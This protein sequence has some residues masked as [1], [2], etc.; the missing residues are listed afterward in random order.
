MFQVF[1]MFIRYVANISYRCCKSRSGC[2]I[3]CN[4]C[5][6]MLQASVLNISSVF[7]D[8][9]ARC[10]FG[11]CICFT[12][13]LQVF[14]LN[15]EYVCNGF[16]VFRLFLMYISSVSYGCC[17]SRSVCCICCN[18]CTRILQAYVPNVL[19]VSS[20][21]MLQVCLFGYC[22]CFTHMLQV[23]YLDVVYVLQWFSSIFMCF[24]KCFTCMF[25]VFHLPS[26]I[27]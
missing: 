9:C 12:H 13:M 18:G 25:Q 2:C 1:Q 24:C 7:S 21:C 5:T 22:I 16:R 3:C 4:G 27:C 15:V 11:C 17:K 6:H 20:R 8:V 26:D 14:Y 10:L 19:F 23:F